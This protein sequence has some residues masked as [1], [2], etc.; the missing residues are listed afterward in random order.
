MLIFFNLYNEGV[1][2]FYYYL[3]FFLVDLKTEFI[4]GCW[5]DDVCIFVY[6]VYIVL[7]LG[8]IGALLFADIVGNVYVFLY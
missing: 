5:T 6:S 7:M 2:V 8:L 4:I 1:I 3:I